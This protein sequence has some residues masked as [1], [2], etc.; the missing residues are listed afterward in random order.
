MEIE[1][2]V[3]FAPELGE[4]VRAAAEQAGLSLSDWMARAAEAKIQADWEAR[5]LKEA[6]QE[7]RFEALREALDEYHAEYGPFTDEQMAE[8]SRK[9]GLPWPPEE[10]E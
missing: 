4:A 9:L 2:S 1:L 6:E 10:N 7:R 3:T 8:A 5:I